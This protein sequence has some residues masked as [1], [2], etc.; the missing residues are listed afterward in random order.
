MSLA[1]GAVHAAP[2]TTVNGITAGITFRD[3]K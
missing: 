1:L 2:S 3:R